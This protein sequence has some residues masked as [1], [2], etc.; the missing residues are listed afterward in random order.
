MRSFG[1]ILFLC[2]DATRDRDQLRAHLYRQ[3]ADN[4]GLLTST[5]LGLVAGGYLRAGTGNGVFRD[6]GGRCRVRTCDFHR[7]KVALYR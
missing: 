3:N 6:V 2:A 4:L 7:V 1:R 5:D